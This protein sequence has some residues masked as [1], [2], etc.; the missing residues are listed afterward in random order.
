MEDI[1]K[2]IRYLR[3]NKDSLLRKVAAFLNIDQAVL[4]KIERGKR[5]IS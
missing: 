5:K 4:S 1:G 3:I 2:L